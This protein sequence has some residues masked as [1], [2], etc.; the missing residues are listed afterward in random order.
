M[1]QSKSR[2]IQKASYR[3]AY[4]KQGEVYKTDKKGNELRKHLVCRHHGQEMEIKPTKKNLL[5]AAI[6]VRKDLVL[7][8]FKTFSK[9][10]IYK[11]KFNDKVDLHRSKNK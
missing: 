10:V 7:K 2:R 9:A 11:N 8:T 4:I 1:K 3:K 6:Y 5:P